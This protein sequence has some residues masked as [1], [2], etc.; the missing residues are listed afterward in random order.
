MHFL[1]N[2]FA[3]VNWACNRLQYLG[4]K[5][6]NS[7]ITLACLLRYGTKFS[8]KCGICGHFDFAHGG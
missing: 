6:T 7:F 5:R 1:R 3:S 8:I 2:V 4:R